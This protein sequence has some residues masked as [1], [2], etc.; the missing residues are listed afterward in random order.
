[1]I[2]EGNPTTRSCE[3]AY[4]CEPEAF[5][6]RGQR[7]AGELTE[8]SSTCRVATPTAGRP[9]ADHASALPPGG[10]GEKKRERKNEKES[11]R[12]VHS[13][14][15]ALTYLPP[16]FSLSLSLSLSLSRSLFPFF[17]SLSLSQFLSLFA[18]APDS[19][20]ASGACR[21]AATDAPA[22]S[23]PRAPPNAIDIK[24]RGEGGDRERIR[25]AT[26]NGRAAAIPDGRRVLP[27]S[28]TVCVCVG[29]F[30]FRLEI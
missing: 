19:S 16:S 8:A 10:E 11:G 13:S 4:L 15:V 26:C 27:C 30:G 25:V 12:P 5:D 18:P 17:F 3:S 28:G 23:L 21:I 6:L 24:G 14:A 1:M 20:R 2:P 7:S 9:C 29:R 22:A